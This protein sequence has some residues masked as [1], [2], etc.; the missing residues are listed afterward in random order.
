MTDTWQLHSS[1]YF[2]HFSTTSLFQ[3]QLCRMESGH[4]FPTAL[5]APTAL[6][7]SVPAVCL[8]H[9]TTQHI[10]EKSSEM[11][12]SV[13]LV[14]LPSSRN[15]TGQYTVYVCVVVGIEA[16]DPQP[17]VLVPQV[18][19]TDAIGIGKDCGKLR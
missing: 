4:S 1:D 16:S 3:P 17:G 19:N 15:Y 6:Q 14:L 12:G 13:S 10:W 8:C 9:R 7:A 11:S 18:Y 2:Q 5:H